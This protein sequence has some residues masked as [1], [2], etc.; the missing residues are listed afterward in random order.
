MRVQVLSYVYNFWERPAMGPIY[1]F[2]RSFCDSAHPDNEIDWCEPIYDWETSEECID[3]IN[4]RKPDILVVTMFVWTEQKMVELCN[5]LKLKN[6]RIKIIG[7]GP[8]ING[9]NISSN[10]ETYPF[11]DAVIYGDGEEAFYDLYKR[12]KSSKE[13]SAGLNCATRDDN[14][15]YQRFKYENYKPYKIYTHETVKNQLRKDFKKINKNQ[16]KIQLV[17]ETDRGCPYSCSYCDWSAGLHHKVS[18]RN[19]DMILQEIND[20]KKY[21]DIGIIQMI[22]ANFGLIKHDEQ[23]MRYM[24]KEGIPVRITNWSKTKKDRVFSMIKLNIQH[25]HDN[26]GEKVKFD[27]S[28]NI[29]QKVAVQ[30]IFKDTLNAINRPDIDWSEYKKL[31]KDIVN[32]YDTYVVIELIS[33]LPLMTVEKHLE[34]ILEMSELKVPEIKYYP[35]ILLAN[36]PAN[37]KEWLD[38]W[39]YKIKKVHS[40]INPVNS[41][42]DQEEVIKNTYMEDYVFYTNVKEKIFIEL[43]YGYYNNVKGD[44][45]NLDK[46]LDFFYKLSITAEIQMQKMYKKTGKNI[47]GMYLENKWMPFE[48]AVNHIIHKFDMRLTKSSKIDFEVK[49]EIINL[50]SSKLKSQHSP[51]TPAC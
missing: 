40:V 8:N 13:I 21:E 36:S 7:G 39:G 22:N 28:E 6:N 44:L 49:N 11:F 48:F 1:Y 45:T 15:Y 5:K 30:S 47:W 46:Y 50:L 42:E 16:T 35:F 31:I 18:I 33:D 20:L 17:Y 24:V 10:F 41:F 23:L 2:L 3:L 26:L 51:R 4:K 38:K 19:T 12:F 29:I 25:G 34:Q 27:K 14:G 37:N 43:L 32:N 9:K